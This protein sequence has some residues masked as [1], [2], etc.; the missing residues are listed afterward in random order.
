MK[1]PQSQE[2][3]PHQS[4]PVS[5]GSVFVG[6]GRYAGLHAN[7][8]QLR[9]RVRD[10]DLVDARTPRVVVNEARRLGL[11]SRRKGKG[12]GLGS[13]PAHLGELGLGPG[14][15]V[16]SEMELESLP[17]RAVGGPRV[18]KGGR[19]LKEAAHGDSLFCGR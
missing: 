17:Q 18:G 12:R 13:N 8:A 6:K 2:P 7:A 10:H 3:G 4:R 16:G 5:I 1:G 19:C 14:E 15:S 9:V 11:R